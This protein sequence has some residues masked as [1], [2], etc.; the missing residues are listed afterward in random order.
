M[1]AVAGG[2][3]VVADPKRAQLDRV[4]PSKKPAR[5]VDVFALDARG[6]ATP[7]K[8]GDIL[9]V[10]ELLP[11]FGNAV[12]LRGNVAQATRTP[13]KANMRITDLIPSRAFLMSRASVKRQND[14]LLS[15][16]DKRN[17]SSD[18]FAR[19]AEA[20]AQKPVQREKIVGDSAD[21][22]ASRIGNLVDEINMDY[23]VVERVD[24]AKVSVQL[25]P[26]S[27]ANALENPSGPDNL[28]L[29]PGD[30]VTVFSVNDVRVPVSGQ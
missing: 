12:T 22:L 11:E 28:A 23:A 21:T 17:A 26:F 16:D 10:S 24:T 4:D 7:L 2:L 1:L 19:L 8:S 30:I 20:D 5:S 25:I 14:V 6:L 18:A 29:Q 13:W 15:D 9:T 3:P 27:L